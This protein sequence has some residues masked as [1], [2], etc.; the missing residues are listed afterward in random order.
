MNK[1]F[2]KHPY[3]HQY[4]SLYSNRKKM[5][6]LNVVDCLSIADEKIQDIVNQIKK[7]CS[8]KSQYS[9]QNMTHHFIYE[10]SLTFPIF[11][12][13][14][15]FDEFSTYDI[16]EKAQKYYHQMM[17]LSE[18]TE[19]LLV[20]LKP[21][22]AEMFNLTWEQLSKHIEKS[23][24]WFET[25][26]KENNQVEKKT[27]IKKLLNNEFQG[28]VYQWREVLDENGNA[29]LFETYDENKEYTDSQNYVL[30]I[31]PENETFEGY[32][33]IDRNDSHTY[34]ITTLD[35]ATLFFNIDEIKKYEYILEDRNWC[36]TICEVN[37][38]LKRK[39]EHIN[40]ETNKQSSSI[41]RVLSFKEKEQL[42]KMNTQS[43]LIEELM[44]TLDDEQDSLLKAQLQTLLN[45]KDAKN[46]QSR[47][48]RKIKV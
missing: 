5:L 4:V 21:Y 9:N 30:F 31:E 25:K 34:H 12:K 42:E 35:K 40:H 43:E 24:L 48:A 26:N 14:A 10:M 36:G 13:D 45:K 47:V 46:T 16:F 15:Y 39:V 19:K 11:K 8:I 17:E 2:I 22:E 29:L 27:F 37:V 33:Y 23:S 6:L 3:N 7:Q 44:L 28:I 18:L 1:S 20:K 32:F 38:E 41:D